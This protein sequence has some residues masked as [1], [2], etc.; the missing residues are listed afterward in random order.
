MATS[1]FD[2]MVA[3][4]KK[5]FDELYRDR[6]SH[7]GE[8][9]IAATTSV[10]REAPTVSSS[11]AAPSTQIDPD[12]PPVR[13]LREC[14]GN[15]WHYEIRERQRDGDEAIVLCKLTF[16]KEGAVRTQF[17]RAKISQLTIVGASNGVRFKTGNASGEGDERDAFRRAT[18]AALINCTDLI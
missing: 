6:R 4:N 17:G 1:T 13:R 12:S 3:R 14:F 8:P 5:R 2:D 16:G 10:R 9:G 18:E 7:A 11:T 15:D